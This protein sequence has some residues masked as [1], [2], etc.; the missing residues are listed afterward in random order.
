[1]KKTIFLIIILILSSVALKADER[2]RTRDKEILLKLKKI[3]TLGDIQ[4]TNCDLCGCYFGIEPN[5]NQNSIGIRY[6]YFKFYSP[7]HTEPVNPALDHEG[8]PGV[9]ETEIYSK[10]ELFGKYNVTPKLRLLLTLPYKFIDINGKSIKDFGDVSLLAQYQIFSTAPSLKEESQY[11]QRV[12]LGAGVKFPTGAFNKQL[13]YGVTEAHFQPGTGA[14]DFLVS[15]SYFSKYKEFGFNT[16]VSYSIATKNKNEY[17]FGN[18]FNISSSLF[19]QIEAG[20][21]GIMPHA[22]VYLEA[23]DKDKLN[24]VED[25]NSGGSVVFFTGGLDIFYG[26]LSLSLN[27]QHPINDKLYGSQTPNDFRVIS[28]LSYYFGM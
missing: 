23:A 10:V 26:S 5:F 27:Y 3:H 6:S 11:R 20:Q 21:T 22:G 7:A 17:H 25:P 13:E 8:H 16:D 9:E 2:D 4:E 12:Y 15:G 28:G 24:E 19:Y 18:R 1:M 14:F